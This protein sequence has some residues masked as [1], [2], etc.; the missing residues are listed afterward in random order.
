MAF[1]GETI[2]EIIFSISGCEQLTP[3]K[4]DRKVE[5]DSSKLVTIK[6]K[7]VAITTT[8]ATG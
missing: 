6:P 4:K 7:G 2:G 8:Q 1:V 5:D 3:S